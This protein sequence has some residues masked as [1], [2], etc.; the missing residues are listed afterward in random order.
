MGR[1]VSVHTRILFPV[2]EVACKPIVNFASETVIIEFFKE[3]MMIYGIKE[4]LRDL[5]RRLCKSCYHQDF[6][7]CCQGVP[8]GHEQL[9]GP[10]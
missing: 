2:L 10:L 3:Y 6:D 1:L 9:N 7:R 8:K 4:L 5:G